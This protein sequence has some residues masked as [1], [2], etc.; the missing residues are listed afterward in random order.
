MRKL[1]SM[2]RH[3][4]G[5]ARV[6]LAGKDYMLGQWGSPEA[7]QNYLR[8]MTE[9]EAANRSNHF[10]ANKMD[11]TI[12]E[13][14]EAYV[15]HCLAYYGASSSSEALRTRP[16]V[17]GLVEIYGDTLAKDYC[18]KKFRATR[19][20]LMR[21]TVRKRKDGKETV[22]PRSRQYVNKLMLRIRRMFKWAA[23]E[24]LV[25]GK[26][27]MDLASVEPLKR[28]RTTAH[29]TKRV[30]SVSDAVVKKTL[31]YMTPV[32]AA[33][34]QFQQLTGC[35]PGE[36][37]KITPRMV[38]RSGDVWEVKLDD[39][40]TAHHDRERVIFVGP[41]A[42]KIL[43][44]Y[45]LRDADANCFSPRESEL[46]RRAKQA[47]E[48]TTPLSCGNVPGS[49]KVKRPERLPGTKYTTGSYDRS[50]KYACKKA[51]PA[52]EGLSDDLIRAWE[53]ENHWSPNQLRH[54]MATNVRK[55]DGKKGLE[56]AS[57]LLGH[58][59]VEITKVYAEADREL[60]I[61]VIKRIG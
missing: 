31:P 19:T 1:P 24:S 43:A 28:G 29:E 49:N 5:K 18:P 37:C 23:S 26:V 13:V 38:D 54:S 40:K 7:T 58:S 39:H 27:W 6:T 48:R 22:I 56:A 60:A 46:H 17:E 12:A 59:D 30:K 50:V 42:Q 9:W 2:R 34:V 47:E 36:V 8:L 61:K 4:S 52:P 21:P 45:L 20:H 10:S 3:S 16:A 41:K 57:I 33:M 53:K 32:V 55:A 44:P 35:R 15:N 51:F 11:V 25:D 14:A